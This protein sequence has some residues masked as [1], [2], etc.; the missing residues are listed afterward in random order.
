MGELRYTDKYQI[1]SN[2]GEWIQ[3]DWDWN[4]FG[5]FTFREDVSSKRADKDW[6]YFVKQVR[7]A[8]GRSVQWV[9]CTELQQRQVLHYHALL[10]N[11]GKA[12]RYFLMDVWNDIAGF[13]RIFLYDKERGAGYYLSKYVVKELGEIK[14]SEKLQDY[15]V[16][17]DRYNQLKLFP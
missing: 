8:C 7:K 15:A 13:A 2:F 9:R 10:L 17:S 5:S 1:Q 11:V 12:D 3:R 14:F 6:L 4:W 16:W